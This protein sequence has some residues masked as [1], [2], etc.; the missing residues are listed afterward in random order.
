MV[1]WLKSIYI[2]LQLKRKRAKAPRTINDAIDRLHEILDS[3]TKSD[4]K[5][6]S[7]SLHWLHH[8]LGQSIRNDWGLWSGSPLQTVFFDLGIHHADDM[9]GIIIKGLICD[10]R[11]TDFSIEERVQYYRK[12]WKDNNGVDCDE[13]IKKLKS[14]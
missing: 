5:R 3:K 4:I 11:G 8:G 9:S 13:E 6:G 12:W 1:R 14:Q 7:A 10:L 2:N